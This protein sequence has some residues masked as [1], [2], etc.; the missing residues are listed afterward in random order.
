MRWVLVFVINSVGREFRLPDKKNKLSA[1]AIA[2][3]HVE[4]KFVM[5]QEFCGDLTK[6]KEQVQYVFLIFG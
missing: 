5:I 6:D 3:N 2:N 4:Q 1:L